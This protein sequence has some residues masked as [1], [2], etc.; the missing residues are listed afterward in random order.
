ML[1]KARN[2]QGRRGFAIFLILVL[3]LSCVPR[4]SFGAAN[5]WK[6]GDKAY[7]KNGSELVSSDGKPYYNYHTSGHRYA[8][9]IAPIN[10]GKTIR[11]YC[12]ERNM[13]NPHNGNTQYYAKTW[14]T[15]LRIN[16]YSEQVQLAIKTALLYGKQPQSTKK[17]LSDLLGEYSSH[18]GECN[19][20]D[21]W[22]ATQ[23]IIWE[24]TDGYRKS[25]A[26]IPENLGQTKNGKV[27]LGT[28]NP[29]GGEGYDFHYSVLRSR[30]ARHI[31]FAML[32][33]MK[34]HRVIPSFTAKEKERA[35]TI[36]M[37][38]LETKDGGVVWKA[39]NSA[40]RKKMTAEER[41]EARTKSD[42]Y[43][44]K[45]SNFCEQ[46][47]KV[48]KT[49]DGEDS[50]QKAYRFTVK[51][52]G[53]ALTYTEKSLPGVVL[54]GKK[55]IPESVTDELLV[56]QN[57]PSNQPLQTIAIGGDDPVDFYF[58]M[59][60]I[61]DDDEK[62]ED[63]LPN[64]PAFTFDTEKQDYNPGWDE[65]GDGIHTGMGDAALDSEISL[66]LDDALIDSRQL[67][68]F[69][70][71]ENNPFVFTP[72]EDVSELDFEEKKTRNE[73]GVLQYTD[74]Y[75]RGE[76]S[77]MT[78]ETGI[79]V[80]RHGENATGGNGA[81]S[82]GVITYFAHRRDYG[83]IEYR[84]TYEGEDG[85]GAVL[86]DSADIDLENPQQMRDEIGSFAYSNDVYRGDLQLVKTKDDLDPFTDRG[87]GDNGKKDYSTSSKWTIR[88]ESEGAENCPYVRVLDKGVTQDSYQKYTHTYQVAKDGSGV[89]ADS[90]HPLTLS[91][92]GQLYVKG[93][94][95]GT[96]VVEEIA[97]D[98]EG[99]V[100]ESFRI[101]ISED[102][103]AESIAV[104]NQAKKNKI[105]VVK[106]NQ[107]TGK[108]VRWDAAR[109]AFQIR[110]LGNPDLSDPTISPNY[111]RW[112]PNGIG[113]TD[114]SQNY[115]FYANENG[116][117]VLPYEL[118]YGIYELRELVVPEGYYVGAFDE[119]G[120]GTVA[121]MGKVEIIDHRG[122]SVKPP[123]SFLE[124]VKV[125][126]K[127][128]EPVTNFS[129]DSE[130]TY[131]SYTFSVLEQSPHEDGKN[132]IKYYAILEIANNPV[133]GKISLT[134]EGE[135]LTGWKENGGLWQ[136]VFEKAA[137]KD[138]VFEIYAAEDILQS[139]GVAPV[140][141]YDAETG[142][143]LS[144]EK[145]YRDHGEV[146]NAKERWKLAL[147]EGGSVL[148]VSD[149]GTLQDFGRANR[150]VTEYQVKTADGASFTDSFTARDEK[151]KMTYRYRV[152]YKM[153]YA[154]GGFCYTD[155]HL[156]KDSISDDYLPEIPM[157]EPVLKSGNQ[158][159][160]IVTMHYEDGNRVRVNA[161]EGEKGLDEEEITG[162]F[163]AYGIDDIAAKPVNAYGGESSDKKFAAAVVLPAGWSQ[164]DRDD[165]Y[166][167]T[168][169]KENYQ[170]LVKEGLLE[171]WIPCD[172]E[173]RFYKSFTQEYSFTL[174]QHYQS[175]NG[176]TLNWDE[177]IGMKTFANHQMETA[178]TE[179]FC[180]E[181]NSPKIVTSKGWSSKRQKDKV[182]LTAAPI[183]MA[184]IYFLNYDGI[185]TEMF[186]SGKQTHT[187]IT[188]T[189]SQVSQF[190]RVLPEISYKG[191]VVP[192][193]EG[194][195]DNKRF[196]ECLFDENTYVRAKR[197]APGSEN[198][199]G[200]Y[201]IEMV[202]NAAVEE[203]CF[204]IT[205]PDTTEATALTGE[206]GSSGILRFSSCD[207]T[208]IYPAGKP[209]EVIRSG[210]N[211]IAQSGLL[212]LGT[213]WVREISTTEGF[214]NQG[215]WTQMQVNY[216]N[217]YTPLV[218]DTAT[219]ENEAVTV[220]ID[221]EKLFETSYQSGTYQK[222][223][224]A[225]FGI[226]TAEHMGIAPDTLV[227]KMVVTD[228]QA[229]AAIKLPLG[230]YYIKETSA[231]EGYK[232][233]HTKYYFDV[234]DIFSA[235]RFHF[236]YQQMGVSG[237]VTQNGKLGTVIDFD[238]LYRYESAVV[239]IDGKDYRLDE[240]AEN[241]TVKISVRGGRTNTQVHIKNG[242]TAVLRLE[243][244]AVMQV[245]ADGLCYKVKLE[246]PMPVYQIGEA[247]ENF[248]VTA[249]Q[250]TT[251]ISYTPKVIRNNWITEVTWFRENQ[252][253]LPTQLEVTS[254]KGS[255]SIL[256][257]TDESKDNG[258]VLLI[259]QGRLT[260]IMVDGKQVA[261]AQALTLEKEQ[262]ILWNFADGITFAAE[263]DLSG[264][265]YLSASGEGSSE[266]NEETDVCR[267]TADGNEKLPKSVQVK[268]T[269][270]K[271]YE[272]NH[273]DT[274]VLSI[275]ITGVKNDRLPEKP[276]KP[277]IPEK[278]EE[279][280]YG[281]LRLTKVDSETG[282]VLAGAEFAISNEE[283][284][285]LYKKTTAR[286]GLL[287]IEQ[288]K[289]GIY[290]YRETKAPSGYLLDEREYAFCI[291]GD[292]EALRVTVKNTMKKRTDVG[293]EFPEDPVPKDG[294][295]PKTGDTNRILLYMALILAGV[296]A[297]VV[298]I[299]RL[300]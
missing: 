268:N 21:W 270:A 257:T 170:I 65:D 195:R 135:R 234:A 235:D 50:I 136:A 101:I 73:D 6:V 281:S 188:L 1:K 126:D 248:D 43:L 196:Y 39:I 82:H 38:Q 111:G 180:S 286:D 173:G 247:S 88:L 282:D 300:K 218:W 11:G 140:K 167:A 144:F 226:Y 221:L 105:K 240:D 159:V 279:P 259:A 255:S 205:Y 171:R 201:T 110:Y 239:N 292:G 30:P 254:Q 266:L 102:G 107:L 72:W 244:D 120:I 250:G 85:K 12:L 67:T 78:R 52:G 275:E 41:A 89:P 193:Y 153:N 58:K 128:G 162:I 213:Y 25:L 31:Y 272:R 92:D 157:T 48:V 274:K 295:S 2:Y 44:L 200:Y 15:A 34:K 210:E 108:T 141:V 87:N 32:R 154:K 143:E 185:R 245:K 130:T 220:Q 265:L 211:G 46:A 233:N 215:Q 263:M 267:V 119:K 299:R 252:E 5:G 298:S 112:L 66:Y 122:M 142:H 290:Y 116:E 206:N 209:V 134:K 138:A 98:S 271:T 238:T 161:L 14:N 35:K 283:G 147:K 227:G 24:F 276:E 175:D 100:L 225:V 37:E 129:G 86:T 169:G 36:Y 57:S 104:N 160:G 155:V 208:M 28:V 13:D 124:T 223:S 61:E 151:K 97:A 69:G 77:V 60:E 241:E 158:S 177:E 113:Y 125:A 79:P 231:P 214:V 93:L 118:E 45:D 192:W 22:I 63:E 16:N 9:C 103:Q 280:K 287:V 243:N 251:T 7:F 54:H 84:I 249:D 75:W 49:K 71:T 260:G 145:T 284:E 190:E 123:K 33:A 165:V 237:T 203:E 183:E 62:E 172:K 207:G 187:K 262:S 29:S 150:T 149:K 55:N 178:V 197:H 199:S 288:L 277:Q 81:R 176:F 4:E 42:Y 269:Q 23:T 242:K 182:V 222:G 115:T 156:W 83:K 26:S 10:G 253:N 139:D 74:Y 184:P 18:V 8:Y 181:K 224:G 228:G 20:D 256:V 95:Y 56:W 132:Y 285:I 17:D 189:E 131:N 174:A 204:H 127:E 80:G 291:T 191:K 296:S 236:D 232:V 114:E 117:I 137:L 19:M 40:Y 212:P 64:L 278:P 202:S 258:A 179:I 289:P 68:V 164:V 186:L 133:M 47:L 109:T 261:Q 96:Y 297:L 216:E 293:V 53:Y 99:Y 76:K 230:K 217:Q 246:G 294:K 163:G 166:L 219:Y 27:V 148:R 94:P 264:N 121:D 273:S 194:L 198:K 146:D 229:S 90:S 3:L 106:T 59:K 152:E 91:K 168:D 51:K 70:S